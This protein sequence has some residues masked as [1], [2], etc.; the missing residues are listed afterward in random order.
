MTPNKDLKFYIKYFLPGLALILTL[1]TAGQ[2][3]SSKL[4]ENDLKEVVGKL[5]LIKKDRYKHH[6]YTDDRIT[7]HIE[8]HSEPFYFFENNI[9]YFNTIMENVIEGEI[10]SIKHRTKLQSI[11]G[12]GSEFKIFKLSKNSIV[13]YNFENTKQHFWNVG[14]FSFWVSLGLWIFYIWLKIKFKTKK[15]AHNSGLAQ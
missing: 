4:T 15:A 10:I 3:Y 5:T 1:I 11:I 14:K 7:I 13:L 9:N 8:G 2:F 12:T 6:K